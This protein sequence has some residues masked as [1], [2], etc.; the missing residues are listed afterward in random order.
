[1]NTFL[2]YSY[3]FFFCAQLMSPQ[4]DMQ[5]PVRTIG[6]TTLEIQ[7]KYVFPRTFCELLFSLETCV[8]MGIHISTR[9]IF[10]YPLFSTL[11]FSHVLYTTTGSTRTQ[12]VQTRMPP[13]RLLPRKRNKVPPR[14]PA[15]KAISPKP[16]PTPTRY[17]FSSFVSLFS[18]VLCF[19]LFCDCW[20]SC[21]SFLCWGA[22]FYSACV[23]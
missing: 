22:C 11:N 12:A 17:I 5:Q 16:W 7:N 20:V 19:A 10:L 1:M 18:C 3:Y 4:L 15:T 8:R 6:A 13:P 2:T 9:A 14:S 21:G 23:L